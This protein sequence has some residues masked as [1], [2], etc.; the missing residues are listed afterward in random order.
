MTRMRFV[1]CTAVGT[2][3]MMSWTAFGQWC[4]GIE[5]LGTLGGRDSVANAISADG[6]VVVGWARRASEEQ[7]AFRWTSAGGMTDVF[8]QQGGNHTAESTGVSADGGC[9]VGYGTDPA[10]DARGFVWSPGSEA[11]L[12]PLNAGEMESWAYGVSANGRV[13]V[14]R[15]PTADGNRASKWVD[16]VGPTIL[17]GPERVSRALGASADGEVIVGHINALVGFSARGVRWSEG[18]TIYQDLGVLEGDDV[19]M[20]L[21]VSDDGQ[22]VV[23]WSS[24]V[25]GRRRAF[26]WTEADG[27]QDLGT[28]GGLSSEAMGVSPDGRVVVGWAWNEQSEARAFRWTA[29]DGMEDLGGLAGVTSAAVDVSANG[30]LIVGYS[31]NED[32][33]RRAVRWHGAIEGCETDL[34]DDGALDYFDVLLMTGW[35]AE[36]DARG[37]VNGDGSFDCFDLFVFLNAFDAGCP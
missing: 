23:G 35:L 14:G 10:Y 27:M 15:T 20:A 25:N 8:P 21:A 12:L 37:D 17:S 1:R 7:A 22:V 9:V 32:G 4:V 18:G 36:G 19:S 11:V 29:D 24:N 5:D 3:L 33:Q 2:A 13:V 26:V 31:Y 28:L 16:G 30:R 34:N 6:S